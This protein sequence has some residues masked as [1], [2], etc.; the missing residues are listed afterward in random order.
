MQ[1]ILTRAAELPARPAPPLSL[2]RRLS[3]LALAA[4]SRLALP[5]REPPPEF[6]HYPLP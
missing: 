1:A 2:R 5:T 4:L 3:A 6:F